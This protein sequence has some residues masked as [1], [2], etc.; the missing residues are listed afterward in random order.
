MNHRESQVTTVLWVCSAGYVF[1][2]GVLIQVII[3]PYLFPSKHGGFG[4]LAGQDSQYFHAIALKM[5]HKIEME[6]WAAWKLRPEGQIISGILSFLYVLFFKRPIVFLP[7]AAALHATATILLYKMA[8]RVVVNQKLA[9]VSVIPF[10]IFPSAMIWYTQIHKDGFF[11]LGNYL[12][13]YS[14]LSLLPLMQEGDKRVKQTVLSGILGILGVGVAWLARPDTLL[15]LLVTG[16]FMFVLLSVWWI[17]HWKKERALFSPIQSVFT[18]FVI[19]STIPAWLL[20]RVESPPAPSEQF[21]VELQWSQHKSIPSLIDRSFYRLALQRE[22]YRHVHKSATSGVDIDVGLNSTAETVRYIPR[23]L[24][25]GLLAPFPKD[26]FD[27][28]RHSHGKIFWLTAVIETVVI[29]LALTLLGWGMITKY[30]TNLAIWMGLPFSLSM[31]TFLSVAIPN[32][33]TLYR[34]RY[35]FLLIL[36]CFGVLALDSFRVGKRKLFDELESLKKR[37]KLNG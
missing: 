28:S 29:Y 1:V 21:P 17:L 18:A 10:V 37:S 30:R 9:L 25:L 6:G 16:S 20:L 32:L 23:A 34:L 4:L 27:I 7:I 3:L 22:V 36:V 26:W 13:L 15:M 5:S 12:F 14:F 33:G 2:V 24:A 19:V 31:I 35:G 11:I 8:R